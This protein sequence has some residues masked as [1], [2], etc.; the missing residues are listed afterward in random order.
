MPTI[1]V[2][3]HYIPQKKKKV[4]KLVI[5]THTCHPSTWEAEAAGSQVPGQP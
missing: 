2:S 5:L 1:I 4:S 3:F